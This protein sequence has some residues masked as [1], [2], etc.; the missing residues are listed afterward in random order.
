MYIVW[1]RNIKCSFFWQHTYTH[2]HA[3]RY[4]H[5]YFLYTHSDVRLGSKGSS[6]VKQHRYFKNGSWTFA[7]I[8]K[9]VPPVVPELISDM[10]TQYF[11]VIDDD[12]DKVD[13]FPTPR[14]S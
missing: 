14:V 11:D 4:T 3:G 10:D 13:S 8:H 7:N 1:F 9:Q 6:E 2:I 5:L 12:K